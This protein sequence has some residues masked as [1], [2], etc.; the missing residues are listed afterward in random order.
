MRF[1]G[2]KHPISNR[3]WIVSPALGGRC[4]CQLTQGTRASGLPLPV[5]TPGPPRSPLLRSSDAPAGLWG[6]NEVTRG[7]PFCRPPVWGADCAQGWTR[8]PARG[9]PRCPTPSHWPPGRRP[10]CAAG[11]AISQ[12]LLRPATR[13]RGASPQKRPDSFS[14]SPRHRDTES[15]A[16]S[17]SNLASAFSTRHPAPFTE[18][19]FCSQGLH[20]AFIKAGKSEPRPSGSASNPRF[21]PRGSLLSPATCFVRASLLSFLASFWVVFNPPL[22]PRL[23]CEPSLSPSSRRHPKMPGRDS[24]PGSLALSSTCSWPPRRPKVTLPAPPRP[25]ATF[26]QPCRPGFR[27]ALWAVLSAVGSPCSKGT[28]GTGPV[29]PRGNRGPAAKSPVHNRKHTARFPRPRLHV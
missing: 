1:R 27:G 15:D 12:R 26:P 2:C 5:R 29:S 28:D 18:K 13:L 21:C 3:R 7:A 6:V 22:R 14:P 23:G 9:H 10:A 16:S 20:A 4:G 24:D 25:A 11:R 8:G 19:P 17:T